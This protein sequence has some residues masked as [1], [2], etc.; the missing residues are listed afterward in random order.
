[1]DQIGEIIKHR[2]LQLG[3]TQYMLADKIYVAPKTIQRWEHNKSQPDWLS[4][5]LL[6]R[7]FQ[8]EAGS[9]QMNSPEPTDSNSSASDFFKKALHIILGVG[10]LLAFVCRFLYL[11]IHR[12]GQDLFKI[13]IKTGSGLLIVLALRFMPATSFYINLLLLTAIY[14]ALRLYFYYGQEVNGSEKSI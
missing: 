8:L 1:M 14:L 13:F 2:R 11:F 5:R 4:R 3:M 7:L 9:L 12:P 6:T 10:A